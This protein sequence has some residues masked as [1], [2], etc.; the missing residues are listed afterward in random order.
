MLAHELDITREEKIAAAVSEAE[1]R[2]GRLDILVN[3]AAIQ[4]MTTWDDLTYTHYQEVLRINLDGALLCSMMAVPALERAGGGR[5]LNT[6]SIMGLVGRGI[7]PVLDRQGRPDQPHPLPGLRPRRQEHHRQ[8]DRARL[9][10]HPH[11]GD[12]RTASTST[13]PSTSRRST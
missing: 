11:G 8:R 6:A 13:R 12:P 10:R 4:D 3:N 2:F 5:I 1:T 9:H 7:D